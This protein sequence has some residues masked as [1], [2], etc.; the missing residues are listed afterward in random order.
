[1]VFTYFYLFLATPNGIP[2]SG[3]SR[4]ERK[5]V[6]TIV[7]Y[8]NVLMPDLITIMNSIYYWGTMDRYEAEKLLDGKPDGAQFFLCQIYIENFRHFPTP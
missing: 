4:A 8:T 5:N 3:L 6:H 1:M 7:E 2:I